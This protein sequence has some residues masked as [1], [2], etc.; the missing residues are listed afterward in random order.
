MTSVHVILALVTTNNWFLHQLDV[1]NAFLHGELNEEVYMKAP[2]GYNIL[3][4][5]VLKLNK[6]LYSLKQASRQWYAKLSTT[7][8]SYGFE[9]TT[10]D[11]SLFIK[12]TNS[13]F[14]AL[15]VSVDMLLLLA[16]K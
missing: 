8:I 13:S 9:S 12:H 1:N 6:S 3:I 10:S 2:K 7:L 4:G 15:L 11:Y 5:K 16:I 14:I